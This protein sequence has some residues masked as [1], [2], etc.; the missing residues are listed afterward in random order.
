KTTCNHLNVANG[1]NRAK[2]KN[3]RITGNINVQCEHIFVRSSV[4][5]TYGERHALVDLAMELDL[6][7]AIFDKGHEPDCIWSYDNMC[8]LTPNISQRWHKYHKRFAYQ[9]DKSRWLIPA[10]HVK[11]HGPGCVPL[12]CYVYKP[13]TSHFHAETA[14]YGWAVFNGVGPSVL[15]M[16]PGHR[17][18]TLVIH[19]GDW[20]WRKTVGLARQLVK[21]LNHAKKQYIEKR[22]HFIGL[23]ELNESRVVAWSAM[24]RSPRVDPRNKRSVISVYEHNHEKAPTLKALVDRLMSSKDTITVSSGDV[25]VGAA[26]SWLQEG[27]ALAQLQA[28]IRRIA[29]TCKA[30][31]TTEVRSRRTKLSTRID[32]WRKEQTRFMRSIAPQLVGQSAEEPEDRCLFLPSDFSASDRQ[33]FRLLGLGNKQVQML[34]VAL[35]DII[36]TLQTTCKTLT[37]AYERKIKHARGQDANTRSNQEIRSIEAKRETLIADYMLFRDALHALGA[38]DEVKWRPLTAKDTFRKSTEK[39]RTPGDSQVTEGNLW[40]MTRAGF[41]TSDPKIAGGLLFEHGNVGEDEDEDDEGGDTS[42]D[43]IFNVND[44]KYLARPRKAVLKVNTPDPNKTRTEQQSENPGVPPEGW[45][46]S[47]GRLKNMSATEIEAWEETN[48]RIQWFRAE[49]DFERWQE[50]VESLHAEFTR[51][52]ARFAKDRDSWATL[53]TKYTPTAGHVAYAKEHADMFESLRV[54]AEMKFRHAQLDFLKTSAGE[55]LADRVLLWRANQETAFGFDR[56]ASRPAFV[57]PTIHVHGGDTREP[58]SED[59][60][61]DDTPTGSK[62]KLRTE[63]PGQGGAR[64]RLAQTNPNQQATGQQNV[65]DQNIKGKMRN[66]YRKP[67]MIP[68]QQ[69][70]LKRNKK[71][72]G[73][74]WQ[75]LRNIALGLHLLLRRQ[76]HLWFHPRML[77][78]PH[79]GLFLECCPWLQ[80]INRDPVLS[81]QALQVQSFPRFAEALFDGFVQDA[82]QTLAA[83]NAV[84]TEG[85]FWFFSVSLKLKDARYM[86]ELSSQYSQI[87]L[88]KC[89]HL[90]V[91]LEKIAFPIV[92]AR[93]QLPL[94]DHE[95]PDFGHNSKDIITLGARKG[96][97]N[98]YTHPAFQEIILSFFY[99]DAHSPVHN[100]N[101]YFKDQ[102]PDN[103]LG[104]V[105]TVVR[106]CINEYRDG[107]HNEIAFSAQSYAR[108]YLAVMCGLAQLCQN[109]IHSLKLTTALRLWETEGC[110]LMAY[111]GA[112]VNRA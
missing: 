88:F 91:Q 33:K 95:M 57:D 48:D 35:G 72:R 45:I 103:V 100:F 55:T 13:C 49:A 110:W 90:E 102:V 37:A 29:K 108:T 80:G 9:I 24:D 25:K 47:S 77:Q 16:N 52:I 15:Q 50:C 18:D 73:S 92:T 41:S 62:R 38:L 3:Q 89:Q 22:D 68:T 82:I 19:Y 69:R 39:R 85:T 4:D 14:E 27:L 112:V 107:Q 46:W 109:A 8:G 84:V 44:L 61:D 11:G 20:N 51:V 87:P 101:D 17:I 36:N 5:M 111:E 59:E 75:L 43:P 63:E 31:P 28:R 86:E 64:D 32:K 7:A 10:C 23:C 94:G 53:A 1:V 42:E 34:E 60:A 76:L 71:P 26:V 66:H 81:I 54:D 99:A 30:N 93:Y 104:L 98:N 2:F 78:D 12:Y 56:W 96:H 106:N 65:N 79:P 21:D 6:E 74:H 83:E 67:S 105:I 40:N 58:P 97:T 70:I